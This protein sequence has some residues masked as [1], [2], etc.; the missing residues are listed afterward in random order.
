MTPTPTSPQ[1]CQCDDSANRCAIIVAIARNN[2]IGIGGNQP[3]FI[4]EDLQRFKKLTTGHAVI[5]GRK[6]FEALPKGALPN[7]RNIVISRRH[8]LQYP[9][10]EVV[11][12]LEK[13]ISLAHTTD[14]QPFVIGGGEVYRQALPLAS[15]LY[16][17][18]IDAEVAQADTFFPEIS[19]AE[20]QLIDATPWQQSAPKSQPPAQQSSAESQSGNPDNPPFRFLTYQRKN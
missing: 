19:D 8:D 4:R 13:A 10:T 20:W 15:S 16:I 1:Q 3:F 5:M 14:S 17:T 2:V 12:S 9:D 6:T 18:E 11:D 7:R